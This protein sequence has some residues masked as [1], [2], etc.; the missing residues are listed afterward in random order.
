MKTKYGFVVLLDALGT[1]TDSIESSKR[2][3]SVISEI[4]SDI[5]DSHAVIVKGNEKGGPNIF[6]ELSIRFFGDTLLVTYEIKDKNREI[7]YFDGISFILNEFICTALKLGLLFRG[8][9]ALGDYLEEGNVVL[10]PAVFDAAV[11]YEKLEMIG[12]IATP[13]TTLSLKSIFLNKY[14]ALD[15]AWNDGV[16]VRPSLKNGAD[17]ELFVFNWPI[18]LSYGENG[19]ENTEKY[20]Y[21]LIRAFPVPLGSESKLQNTENFFQSMCKS[22]AWKESPSTQAETES[23]EA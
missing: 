11:W 6:D 10:G 15:V 14:N 13:K 3:L 18:S 22:S 8:S 5:K 4:E 16:F 1:K 7:D 2:Y 20:F 23:P 12:V 17:A 9:I 21:Q 19:R